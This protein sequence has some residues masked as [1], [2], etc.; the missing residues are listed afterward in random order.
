M[1]SGTTSSEPSALLIQIQ[2]AT[3]YFISPGLRLTI[4]N[5]SSY[6]L[7]GIPVVNDYNGIQATPTWRVLAGVSAVFGP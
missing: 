4:E 2:A 6:V 5:W 1:V 7:V 3:R